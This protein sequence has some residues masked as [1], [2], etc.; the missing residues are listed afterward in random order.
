VLALEDLFLGLVRPR[1]EL[2]YKGVRSTPA[3]YLLSSLLLDSSSRLICLISRWFHETALSTLTVRCFSR[4]FPE[5][6]KA[7]L[8]RMTRFLD[9]YHPM[10][11]PFLYPK[12]TP[13]LRVVGQSL[14]TIIRSGRIT[15]TRVSMVSFAV[16][17]CSGPHT[18]VRV[19]LSGWV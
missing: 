16:V 3:V 11:S 17:L 4:H 8:S 15:S 7:K 6:E 13:H 10:P 1:L 18:H 12:A 5:V 19:G 2:C 14:H 9:A